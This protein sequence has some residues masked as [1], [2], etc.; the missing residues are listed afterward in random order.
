[1]E[2]KQKK[3]KP[4]KEKQK[5][6]FKESRELDALPQTI[7]TLEEEKQRLTAS[8]SSP[9]FYASRDLAK[10]NGVNDRLDALE[11]ELDAAYHRWDELESM[12]KKFSNEADSSSK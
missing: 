3:V 2:S 6:S 5:L 9:E 8:L 4:P 1:M 11:K 10:I 7:E 12:I